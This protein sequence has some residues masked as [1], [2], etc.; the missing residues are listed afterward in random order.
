MDRDWRR[1][2]R[3][4]SCP[5]DGASPSRRPNP[6][7]SSGRALP[8]RP[9]RPRS[10]PATTSRCWAGS[11]CAVAA[12]PAARPS[13]ARYPVVEAG[14]GL[15]SGFLVWHFGYTPDAAARAAADLGPDRA[16]RD[17]PRSPAA[18]RRDHPAAA[19]GR[20][21][22]SRA[23]WPAPGREPLRREPVG[24]RDWRHGWLPES[25][26]GLPRLPAGHRQGGHGLRRLQ[27]VRGAAR[28]ARLPDV[29]AD[30]PAL[31]ADRRRYWH[32]PRSRW[33]GTAARNPFRS[34]RT[35]QPLAS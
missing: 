12:P 4:S 17:R 7:T 26:A 21:A 30:P 31:G 23:L 22:L 20:P 10:R 13:P 3:R 27:V 1:S 16:D 29:S 32:R 11:G 6:S 2:A 5:A 18:A 8:A 35:S 14:T 24:R 25:L 34:A 19:L 33:A 28:V 9:A 15:V